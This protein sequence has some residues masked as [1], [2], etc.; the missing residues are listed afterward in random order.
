MFLGVGVEVEVGACGRGG[1]YF[2]EIFIDNFVRNQQNGREHRE[3]VP[4]RGVFSKKN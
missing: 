4:W 3:Y 1:K 2:F